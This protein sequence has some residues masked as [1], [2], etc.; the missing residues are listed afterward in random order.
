M[1]I[2]QRNPWNHHGVGCYPPSVPTR[3]LIEEECMQRGLGTDGCASRSLC[4][5][6]LSSSGCAFWFK[7]ERNI[8][9]YVIRIFFEN[10]ISFSTRFL[11]LISIL[12]IHNYILDPAQFI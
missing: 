4:F 12:L 6:F 2:L 5:E 7:K 8:S 3:D 1:D 10:P 11:A 9:I